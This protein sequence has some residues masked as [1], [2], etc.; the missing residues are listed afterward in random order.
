MHQGPGETCESISE[1]DEACFGTG[2]V[3][4]RRSPPAPQQVALRETGVRATIRYY[5]FILDIALCSG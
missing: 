4:L 3:A 1:R 5:L 2:S